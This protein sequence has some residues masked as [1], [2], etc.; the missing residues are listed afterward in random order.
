MGRDVRWWR[1]GTIWQE[2]RTSCILGITRGGVYIHDLMKYTTALVASNPW[3]SLG[4]PL[5][6]FVFVQMQS[7]RS[8]LPL[9]DEALYWL[10]CPPHLGPVPPSPSSRLMPEGP[11][12]CWTDVSTIKDEL[13]QVPAV[14]DQ[15]PGVLS[16]MMLFPGHS[17]CCRPHFVGPSNGDN[18]FITEQTDQPLNALLPKYLHVDISPA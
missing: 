8:I 16:P 7:S 17:E 12:D 13:G 3:S 2:D 4:L 14:A 9:D 15:N 18:A 11:S 6:L 1:R 5:F 10:L